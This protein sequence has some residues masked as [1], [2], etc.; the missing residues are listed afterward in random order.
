MKN[1]SRT[2]DGGSVN[3]PVSLK[4]IAQHLGLSKAT[5][6]AVINDAP[7]ARTIPQETKDRIFKAVEELN[8]HPNYMARSLRQK[9]SFTVGVLVPEVSE[10][11]NASVIAGIEDQLAQSGYLY[12]VAS[13]RNRPELIEKYPRLLVERAV[14][15][16]IFVNTPLPVGVHVPIVTVGGERKG[17]NICNILLD[18]E[19]GCRLAMEH[20]AAL[21]HKDVALFKGHPR[22]ADTDLR[23][24]SICDAA[25]DLGIPIRDELWIQLRGVAGLPEASTSEEGYVYAQRLLDR[26]QHFTALFAFNDMSAIGAASAF[27][28]AGLKLPEDV[29]LIGFDDIPSASFQNPRLTTVRQPLH[30]MGVLAASTLLERIANPGTGPQQILVEPELV[31][32]E[33]TCAVKHTQPASRRAR[34]AVVAG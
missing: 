31:V 17:P 10:G 15:G 7:P 33:S 8:Y 28:D 18:H 23:W 2:K 30:E 3:V 4:T 14:E 27:R 26:K 6:S 32:R 5:I 34:R 19:K 22:S 20:L 13:H 9:R 21:G 12:Y 16:F 11:Y 29:S 24:K 25:A 1:G